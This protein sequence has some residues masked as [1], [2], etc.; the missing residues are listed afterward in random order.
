MKVRPARKTDAPQISEVLTR[1]IV[2]LCEID[3]R[4]DRGILDGWLH[5]KTP[6]AVGALIADPSRQVMIAVD[7][8]RV[9]CVGATGPGGKIELLYV[10]PDYRFRGVS[11]QVLE[12]LEQ[13]LL[14]QG[15]KEVKLTSS[16]TALPFYFA[17]GYERDGEP[18]K[19]RADVMAHPMRKT[20]R[21]PATG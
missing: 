11:K 5:N 4:R 16:N 1:C 12:A 2:E 20:L 9:A 8:Q 14:K 7:G 21:D 18:V 17:A 10:S 13:D 15:I 19:W 6:D 3:H